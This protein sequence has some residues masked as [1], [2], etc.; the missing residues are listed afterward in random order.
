[1]KRI[2]TAKGKFIDMAGLAKKYE[3]TRAVGNVPMN[4]KGDRLDK[5]GNV[6]AT[7]Q[8]VSRAQHDAIEPAQPA[9]LSEPIATRNDEPKEEVMATAPDQDPV[10]ISEEEKTREDG[11]VYLEIEYDDGSMETREIS[12]E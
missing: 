3:E 4:A 6:K 10:V 1:M 9:P 5:T 7:I 2:K 8:N 11:T 12:E